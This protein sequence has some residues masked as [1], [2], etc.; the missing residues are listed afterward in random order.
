MIKC[1][2]KCTFFIFTTK[3]NSQ[4]YNAEI[5]AFFDLFLT[6]FSCNFNFIKMSFYNKNPKCKDKVK[7]V[8]RR[9]KNLKTKKIL[10]FQFQKKKKIFFY[11]K[12]TKK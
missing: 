6:I 7:K 8:L 3:K 11:K 12:K 4:F 9:E 10:N 1:Y 2:L 5:C